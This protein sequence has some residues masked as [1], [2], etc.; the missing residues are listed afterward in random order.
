MPLRYQGPVNLQLASPCCACAVPRREHGWKSLFSLASTL[1]DRP[2][3]ACGSREVPVQLVVAGCG[4]ASA[5]SDW[6]S[7]H[8]QRQL[9]CD[10]DAAMQRCKQHA[11]TRLQ[12]ATVVSSRQRLAPTGRLHRRTPST[13]SRP[14]RC[15]LVAR[16]TAGDHSAR[17]RSRV[18]QGLL[19]FVCLGEVKSPR[20]TEHSGDVA[21]GWSHTALS[22]RKSDRDQA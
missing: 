8:R 21:T 4:A 10:G 5:V 7:A 3:R 18:T 14:P 11:N 17:A 20:A 16:C 6:A 1:L 9:T 12:D 15:H 2:T 19:F 13:S 22:T